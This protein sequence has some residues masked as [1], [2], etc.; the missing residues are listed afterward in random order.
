[1]M[2]QCPM[3]YGAQPSANRQTNLS[4]VQILS[5]HLLN[6]PSY[7]KCVHSVFLHVLCIFL[8]FMYSLL[9]F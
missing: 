5:A 9:H 4:N 7:Q 2:L 8:F 1:M 3:S 6:C